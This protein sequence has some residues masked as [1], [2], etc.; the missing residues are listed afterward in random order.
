M[1][2]LLSFNVDRPLSVRT[3]ASAVGVSAPISLRQVMTRLG[4]PR[5]PLYLIAHRCNDLGAV[6]R[7]VSAGANA[8]ECDIQFT[9]AQRDVGSVEFVVNHDNTW[10]RDR[11]SLIP[12]LNGV[13]EIL[14]DNPQVALW[15]FDLK[16]DKPSDAVRL[17]NV[18]RKHL[19]DHVPINIIMSQASLD[20]GKF[21]V[22]IRNG[23]RPRE[24]YAIDAYNHPDS[25]SDFFVDN[26]IARHGYGNGIFVAGGGERV[27]R[28]R[29]WRE[30]P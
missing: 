7:A 19:T 23:I 22:P 10:H 12:Y 26:G 25:V 16:D 3:L 17:R 11:D 18:I 29:S 30:L 20:S 2:S 4:E 6:R 24:G 9:D 5:R 21:F 1:P 27:F 13:V 15:F 8:I 28:A 14:R